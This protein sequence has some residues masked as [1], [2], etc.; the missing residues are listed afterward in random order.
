MLHVVEEANRSTNLSPTY[1]YIDCRRKAH[2]SLACSTQSN[3]GRLADIFCPMDH[4]MT[5]VEK[6]HIHLHQH[7]Q[8]P[9]NDEQFM[10]LTSQE[11]YHG[12]IKDIYDFCYQN[13]LMQVWAYL[14]N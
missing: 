1:V 4:C 6:F 7:P 13:D 2:A 5:I 14:W 9:L 12:T 3:K 11:I 10:P 8:I